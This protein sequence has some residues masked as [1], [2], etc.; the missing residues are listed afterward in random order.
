M[1]KIDRRTH[2]FTDR[3][4]NIIH[5]GLVA[6]NDF[7]QQLNPLFLRSLRIGIKGHPCRG[8]G[9]VYIFF[10]PQG[11]RADDFFRRRIDDL[12]GIARRGL[13]PFTFI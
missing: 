5:T 10:T 11:H 6:V 13:D 8:N 1:R 2:F 3:C 9:F 4:R 7:F 12:Q